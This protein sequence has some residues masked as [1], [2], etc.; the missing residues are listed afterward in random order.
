[1]RQISCEP[2]FTIATEVSAG[3]SIFHVVVDT[4]VTA[5]KIINTMNQR[6]MPGRVTFLV[7]NRL[8]PQAQRYP[9]T[10]NAIPLISKLAFDP[11]FEPAVKHVFDRVLVCR[12]MQVASQLARSTGYDCI[13]LQGDQVSRKGALTGGYV[14]Q[15]GKMQA[16]RAVAEIKQQMAELDDQ[17]ER[18]QREVRPA[19]N[20][21][22]MLTVRS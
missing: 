21:L 9:E 14:D 6:H 1:M 20:S 19:R 7:L 4:D 13:T 5:S 8:K 11:A 2:E 12:D 3:N 17:I 22:P 15:H 18:V 10:T 16:Q